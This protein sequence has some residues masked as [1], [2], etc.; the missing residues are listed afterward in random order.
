MIAMNNARAITYNINQ[1]DSTLYLS[2]G[3]GI[4]KGTRFRNQGV[5][6]TLQVPVGKR[7][8]VDKSVSRK[9]EWFDV[10]HHKDDW[11]DD[12]DHYEDWRSNVEYVM[13]V[14]GLERVDKSS[15]DDENHDAL[16]EFKK[17]REQIEKEREEKLRELQELDKELKKSDSTIRKTDSTYRYKP[18]SAQ[19]ETEDEEEPVAV[20]SSIKRTANIKSDLTIRPMASFL[21]YIE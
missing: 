19:N 16:E 8:V 21:R 6:V 17:S 13:T 20:R 14:G 3:F 12:W 1:Q 2:R 7:I 10:R 15:E 5:I 4:K 18:A 11:D 9:L